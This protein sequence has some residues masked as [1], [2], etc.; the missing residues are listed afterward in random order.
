ML[1]FFDSVNLTMKF[2]FHAAVVSKLS[3]IFLALLSLPFYRVAKVRA[4]ILVT[5]II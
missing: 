5:K 2:K 3:K 4:F 1:L